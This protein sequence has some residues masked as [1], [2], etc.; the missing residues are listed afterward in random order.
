MSWYAKFNFS[1]DASDKSQDPVVFAEVENN[2]ITKQ[3]CFGDGC[4][5][6]RTCGHVTKQSAN[7]HCTAEVGDTAPPKGLHKLLPEGGTFEGLCL[8]VLLLCE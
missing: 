1:T 5:K 3:R 2:G 6:R 8:F 7:I 4:A